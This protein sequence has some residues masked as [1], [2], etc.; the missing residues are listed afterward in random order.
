MEVATVPPAPDC[1]VV[2]MPEPHEPDVPPAKSNRVAVSEVEERVSP[3]NELKHLSPSLRSVRLMPPSKNS[4][5]RSLLPTPSLKLAVCHGTVIVPLV[6]L[7]VVFET[8]QA[9]S[10]GGV[11][12]LRQS[13]PAPM[14]VVLREPGTPGGLKTQFGPGTA[15]L[16]SAL[17]LFRSQR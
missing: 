4:D 11:F 7:A 17:P 12:A 5:V 16:Q 2:T 9:E 14:G 10:P 15:R 8:A 13:T 1:G 6:P 3:M